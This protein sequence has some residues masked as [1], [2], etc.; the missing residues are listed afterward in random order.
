[1]LDLR[2]RVEGS[3]CAWLGFLR[4]RN[5]NRPGRAIWSSAFDRIENSRHT[6]NVASAH[7]Q[8]CLKIGNRK[9]YI[10]VVRDKNQ[11][12]KKKEKVIVA[13][14]CGLRCSAVARGA[15]FKLQ[16]PQHAHKFLIFGG[17]CLFGILHREVQTAELDCN[18]DSELIQIH[19]TSIG[20][21]WTNS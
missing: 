15:W 12:R 19:T 16:Y 4:P 7:R 21:T 9:V 17:T 10:L 13:L 11:K 1:M 3:R 2:S 20:P 18:I 6:S 14:L 8:K 5:S